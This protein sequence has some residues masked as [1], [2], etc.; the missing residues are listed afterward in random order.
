MQQW[1]V[2]YLAAAT[3]NVRGMIDEANKL[4]SQGW[5]PVGITSADK[6][7]GLNSNILIFKRPI[8]DPPPS[9]SSGD[10]WQEDPTGRFDKRRWDGKVWTAE[11]AMMDAKTLHVD[12][13]RMD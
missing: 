12:P 3:N 8:L 4:A 7:I 6:T 10:E 1:E 13:P 9:P 11:T 5:E 2:T